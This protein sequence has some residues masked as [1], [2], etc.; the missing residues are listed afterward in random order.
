[1][2]GGFPEAHAPNLCWKH[3][4]YRRRGRQGR[5]PDL[6]LCRA[7]IAPPRRAWVWELGRWVWPVG[8]GA[9]TWLVP[10]R[11]RCADTL[12]TPGKFLGVH[13]CK[14]PPAP[15]RP[16][17]PLLARHF[18]PSHLSWAGRC[19]CYG[20][21]L[22]CSGR[23]PYPKPG[24]TSRWGWGQAGGKSLLLHASSSSSGSI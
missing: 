18:A 24:W 7:V 22:P 21:D 14:G 12:R 3:L 5:P 19:P 23:S 13:S 6:L 8:A 2:G 20:R 4:S 16:Q 9:G 1:M 15:V 17:A 11:S 10:V